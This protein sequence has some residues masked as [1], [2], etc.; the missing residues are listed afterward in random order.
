MPGIGDEIRAARKSAGKTQQEVAE[1]LGVSVQAISQW[2]NGHTAPALANL[3]ELKR[4]IGLNL[5]SPVKLKY[6]GG[7]TL[8]VQGPQL[9]APAVNWDNPDRWERYTRDFLS[10]FESTDDEPKWFYE[11]KWRPIGD[12]FALEVRKEDHFAPYF[13]AGDVTIID[14]GRA[15]ER[16]DFVVVHIPST[17][18][19]TKAFLARYWP[20]GIDEHRAVIFELETRHE[21]RI[22]VDK[23]KPGQV[24]G[25]VRELRRYF[26]TD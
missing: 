2:E 3:L 18:G 15:P 10:D 20:I 17:A 1:R 16:G 26:R 12:V 8:A 9:R 21:Q 13:T 4:F 22:R 25:T 23:D 24:L 14:T 5:D 11:V 7:E 19:M 6:V